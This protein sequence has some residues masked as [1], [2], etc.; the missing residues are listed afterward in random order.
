[1]VYEGFVTYQVHPWLVLMLDSA[2]SV[3][4]QNSSNPIHSHAVPVEEKELSQYSVNLDT[5]PWV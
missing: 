3:R 4:T 5:G 2:I 1:M